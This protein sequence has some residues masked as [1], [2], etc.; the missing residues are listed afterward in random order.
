MSRLGTNKTNR[1]MAIT[2]KDIN[3]LSQKSVVSGAEKIPVSDTQYITPSQIVA[4]KVDKA[5]GTMDSDATLTFPGEDD[6]YNVEI[7]C[8]GIIATDDDDG[9]SVS[10][11][12]GLPSVVINEGSDYVEY[13]CGFIR[14]HRDNDTYNF[15]LPRASGT[16]A[17]TSQIPTILSGTSD[18]SNSLGNDGDI[19]IKLSSE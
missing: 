7:S 9:F 5:G 17:L 12:S 10:I 3:Q 18:P 14:Y 13:R 4:S 11:D 16:L 2:Y 19:Y 8:D 6:L 1:H 15:L